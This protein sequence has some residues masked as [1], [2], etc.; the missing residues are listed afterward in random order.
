MQ[1]TKNY[2]LNINDNDKNT[3]VPFLNKTKQKLRFID[4]F[5][6][7]GGFH[8]AIENVAE[9]N[10]FDI[11]CVFVSEI[12]P[13]AI[14]TYINN[15]NVDQNKI[16]NIRDLDNKASQVNDHDF[17]FAGFPCQTFSNAGKKL[18]FL[19]E[20]RGTLFFDIVKILKNKKPK[21]I[22]LENV[23]HLINHDNGKTWD[24]IVKILKDDLGYMIPEKP[25]V[26]SPNDFGIPQDRKR[27]YIPGVLRTKVNNPSEFLNIDDLLKN[28]INNP[29]NNK[30]VLEVKDYIWNNFLLHDVDD[31]Y[32]L[33]PNNE[34]NKYLLKVFKAW[35]EFLKNVKRI[36]NRTLPVIWAYELGKDY[37][38]SN[39]TDWH[40]KYILDMREIY[41]L[42]KKFIDNWLV[43]YDV[44]SWKKREQKL[45]WQAGKDIN[46]LK[47]AFIQL[48]QS[49]IRCKRP[50]K[51]PTLVAMVQIPLIFDKNKNT[52]RYL[53]PREVANLQ[54]FPSDFKI[55]NEIVVNGNDYYSYK[56]FGNSVN[57]EIISAIQQFLLERY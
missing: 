45:E 54:S 37:D 55:Y 21:Y 22:L 49:G 40:K 18:G 8:K 41:N 6:G 26:L 14:T 25:L 56:Q 17:L 53:S 16:I 48:R 11:E 34:S 28:K 23:K 29:L 3:L 9:K 42:N 2:I 7:I 43:K 35:N 50:V 15:F 13:Y 57:I 19:D 27:V 39:L 12:D 4:L 20:I 51:F 30:N 46:D 10:N 52:W 33:K 32:C 5:A 24:T 1:E 31:K 44:K 47:E 36:D 38:I